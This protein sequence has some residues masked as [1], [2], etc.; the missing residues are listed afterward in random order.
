[1]QHLPEYT[2]PIPHR[3]FLPFT[4][5]EVARRYRQH[6]DHASHLLGRNATQEEAEALTE[7]CQNVV[8][9]KPRAIMFG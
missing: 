8:L 7:H 5:T 1:M 4:R 3:L 6:I 9:T 2:L